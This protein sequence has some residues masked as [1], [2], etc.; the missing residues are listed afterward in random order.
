MKLET[1][2]FTIMNRKTVWG[3]NITNKNTLKFSCYLMHFKSEV[4]DYV[5]VH[6][7]AHSIEPNHSKE[8][9]KIVNLYI[10]DYKSVKLVLKN[11]SDLND[12]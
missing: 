12:L 11:N 8:F 9:W 4:I 3:L 5:I 6:E 7:L 1:H 2:I 10:P